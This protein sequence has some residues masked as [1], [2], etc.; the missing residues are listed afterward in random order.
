MEPF[1]GMVDAFVF[2]ELSNDEPLTK[3][4]KHYLSSSLN[5]TL[6]SSG[7]SL[8]TVFTDFAQ[9]Y[10]LY[11]EGESE[12]LVVPKWKGSLHASEGI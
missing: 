1:R 7:K 5:S 2:S 12:S 9:Q 11:V 8:P 6:D 4:A 3:E 10:G